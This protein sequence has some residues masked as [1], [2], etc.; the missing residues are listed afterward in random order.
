MS[1][2]SR[3][4]FCASG[5]LRSCAFPVRTDAIV[6]AVATEIAERESLSSAELLEITAQHSLA[7][8]WSPDDLARLPLQ[9]LAA[10]EGLSTASCGAAGSR[11][12]R[13]LV[14]AG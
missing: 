6:E 9:G 3:P 11:G 13:V 7:L 12:A 2:S 8:E 10:A 14:A 4:R 1:R 5:W